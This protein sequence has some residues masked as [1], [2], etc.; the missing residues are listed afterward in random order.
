MRIVLQCVKRAAVFYDDAKYSEIGK[1][2]T[3]VVGIVSGDGEEDMDSVVRTVTKARL[4]SDGEKR[5]RKSVVGIGGEV[6]CISNFT[7][8]GGF[9]K[10][11]VPSFASAMGPDEARKAFSR[12]VEKL[13]EVLGDRVKTGVFGEYTE[14]EQLSQGVVNMVYDSKAVA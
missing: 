11:V 1:G 13:R 9:N 12:L 4:F 10:K 8:A 3:V 14:I 6:L 7:L 5:W 2:L